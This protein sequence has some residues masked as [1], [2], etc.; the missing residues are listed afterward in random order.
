MHAEERVKD[1]KK[2]NP[3]C[4]RSSMTK[5]QA[6]FSRLDRIVLHLRC[7]WRDHKYRWHLSGV[8]REVTLH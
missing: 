5:C 8:W 4:A 1:L 7:L 3:M 2:T 6:E